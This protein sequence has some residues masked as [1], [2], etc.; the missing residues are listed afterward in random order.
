MWWGLGCGA[1][2][3]AR[4]VLVI[5]GISLT[6]PSTRNHLIFFF[7][8]IF[9]KARFI[10]G[11]NGFPLSNPST[12]NHFFLLHGALNMVNI[13]F[14]IVCFNLTIPSSILQSS[15]QRARI[16]LVI[17]GLPLPIPYTRN[18]LFLI[19]GVFNRARVM[20]GIAG[21]PVAI[22]SFYGLVIFEDKCQVW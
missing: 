21:L 22:S 4:I 18:H 5:A 13:I 19:Y 1:F 8:V 10:L 15:F 3:R 12:R 17:T 9:N 6:I 20:F 16:L 7:H 14:C 2:N 11:I